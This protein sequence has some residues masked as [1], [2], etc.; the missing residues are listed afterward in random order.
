MTLSSEGFRT[1]TLRRDGKCS[2]CGIELSVG[3]E[4][5]WNPSKRIVWCLDHQ[6]FEG[7]HLKHPV[8]RGPVGEEVSE[9]DTHERGKAGASA[10]AE[11]DRRAKKREDRVMARAPRIGKLLLAIYDDP[12]STKAWE[13]GAEGEIA[14]GRYLD[15]LAEKYEFLVLHDRLIPKSRA[16][17]DHIAIT[18]SG[19]FVIDAK[20]Y[21]GTIQIRDQSGF[22]SA[23]NPKLW[24]G[25]RNC[26]K[27]I[28]GMKHQVEVVKAVLSD[29]HIEMPVVGVL[30]FYL[31]DWGTYKF[32]RK[33]EVID[34]VLI[35]SK[36]IEPIVSKLGTHLPEELKMVSRL[37]AGALKVAS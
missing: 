35:N 3:V 14:I 21:Q 34:G 23:P 28:D 17:I 8:L 4:A 12:Q 10:M 7:E 5:L 26:M 15:S 22:F 2:N 33:Q 13:V 27:L 29:H 31:A 37:L 24:V 16:N 20:N 6:T 1:L 9:I 30:A 18:K 25:K 11:H 36:G 32:M 19:I